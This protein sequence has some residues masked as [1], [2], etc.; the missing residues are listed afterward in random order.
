[1]LT[2]AT[3]SSK[4]NFGQPETA[5]LFQKANVTTSSLFKSDFKGREREEYRVVQLQYQNKAQ[6]QFWPAKDRLNFFW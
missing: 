1:M 6:G 5:Q 3:F 2:C 4:A